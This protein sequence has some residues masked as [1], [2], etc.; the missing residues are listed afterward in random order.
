MPRKAIY[1][2][3]NWKD[4][5][6]SLINRGNITLWF[7]EA[8]INAWYSAVK[9][10]ERGRDFTYSDVAIECI[11]SFRSMF[12]LA[13]RQT[14]GFVEGLMNLLKISLEVPNYSTLSR[15]TSSLDVNL[16]AIP[17]CYQSK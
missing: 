3:K 7:D 15:R 13:L 1:R 16:S 5:N 17:C 8:V 11:L 6:K 12:G 2:V 9:N 14:Q 4:Y 10:G